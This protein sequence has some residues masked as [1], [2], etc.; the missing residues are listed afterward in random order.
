MKNHI[1]VNASTS[2]GRRK[3]LIEQM[4]LL[5]S[6]TGQFSGD[7]TEISNAMVNIHNALSVPNNKI[8]ALAVTSAIISTVSLLVAVKRPI[9]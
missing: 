8:I 3:L 7:P 1:K 4:E 5:K 6:E 2:S 9:K